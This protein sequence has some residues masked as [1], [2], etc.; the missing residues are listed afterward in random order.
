MIRGLITENLGDSKYR[1]QI[2]YDTARADAIVARNIEQMVYLDEAIAAVQAKVIEIELRATDLTAQFDAKVEALKTAETPDQAD[3]IKLELDSISDDHDGLNPEL[4]KLSIAKNGLKAQKFQL[5]KEN[6]FIDETKGGDIS[7]TAYSNEFDD[8]LTGIVPVEL[9]GGLKGYPVI[10]QSDAF[11]GRIARA[12][13]VKR[14][15]C[16]S[17][18]AL[19]TGWLKWRQKHVI[20]IVQSVGETVTASVVGINHPQSLIGAVQPFD[21]NVFSASTAY[22]YEAGDYA[23]IEADQNGL[24]AFKGW[25]KNPRQADLLELYIQFQTIGEPRG[26]R[27]GFDFFGDQPLFLTDTLHYRNGQM[28]LL[29]RDSTDEVIRR[30]EINTAGG[31]ESWNQQ[32]SFFDDPADDAWRFGFHYVIYRTPSQGAL[33]DKKR[34]AGMDVFSVHGNTLKV[35]PPYFEEGNE[36]TINFDDSASSYK[37]LDRWYCPFDSDSGE[38]LPPVKK[39]ATLTY[40]APLLSH[41]LLIEDELWIVEISLHQVNRYGVSL[42]WDRNFTILYLNANFD[43]IY[44]YKNGEGHTNPNLSVKRI[45]TLY[46]NDVIYVTPDEIED[47]YAERG[48]HGFTQQ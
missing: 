31:W 5:E 32:N 9:I 47:Y 24:Q 6:A 46:E 40:L 44:Q 27:C 13:G 22:P 21:L 4:Q 36:K 41:A 17:N 43:L 45:D 1:V 38:Y 28:T 14:E 19:L 25:Y 30:N 33:R 23:L 29:G 15:H 34:V 8:T 3:A 18:L 20:G 2:S 37:Y 10:V 12:I 42:P 7:V 11:N 35:G 26:Y 39:Y 48:W 16:F